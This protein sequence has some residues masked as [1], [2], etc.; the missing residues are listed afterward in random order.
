MLGVDTQG[1]ACPVGS[2]L[3]AAPVRL[4]AAKAIGRFGGSGIKPQ[5]VLVFRLGFPQRSSLQQIV[6][7]FDVLHGPSCSVHGG[8]PCVRPAPKLHEWTKEVP[9]RTLSNKSRDIGAA[10]SIDAAD[11]GPI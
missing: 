4:H 3:V 9:L 11:R 2:G 10:R 8:S 6:A 7:G 5:R 1:P